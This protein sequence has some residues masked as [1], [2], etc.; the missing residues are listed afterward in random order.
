MP[1]V[2]ERHL[3]FGVRAGG[4]GAQLIESLC[5]PWPHLGDVCGEHSGVPD[6]NP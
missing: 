4:G 3:A 5:E 6:H 1:D 2:L